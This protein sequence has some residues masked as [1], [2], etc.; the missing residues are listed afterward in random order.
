[1]SS[2]FIFYGPSSFLA[3]I[4]QKQDYIYWIVM[5]VAGLCINIYLLGLTSLAGQ[6]IFSLVFI[7][8]GVQGLLLYYGIKHIQQLE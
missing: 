2:I 5:T 8:C 1:M 7:Y 4:L 6:L 3:D